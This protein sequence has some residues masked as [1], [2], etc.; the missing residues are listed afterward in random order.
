MK[1]V[2]KKNRDEFELDPEK[3][4]K[5][6]M[7]LDNL[8]RSTTAPYPRGVWRLTHAQ[9]NQMDLERQTAQFNRINN[10]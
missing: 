9:M 2:G 1:I 10:G 5:R 4:W 3:A 6:G 7:A 8:L